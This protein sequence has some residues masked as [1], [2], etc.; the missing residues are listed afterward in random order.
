[1]T[2]SKRR[3]RVTGAGQ[4]QSPSVPSIV[5]RAASGAV[6][7]VGCVA[8]VGWLLN[9]EPLKTVVPGGIAMNP[10]TAVCFLLGSLALWLLRHDGADPRRLLAGQLCAT[11]VLLVGLFRLLGYVLGWDPGI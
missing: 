4:T 1:M 6:A 5:T 9:S 11:V 10:A 8:L 3:P 7:A 2:G